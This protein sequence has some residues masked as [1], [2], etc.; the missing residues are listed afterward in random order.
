MGVIHHHAMIVVSWKKENIMAAHK[1]AKRLSP[2]TTD[3]V[4]GAANDYMSF[5]VLP[6]GSKEGW[7]ESDVGD[8]ARASLKDWID[9]Q[10]YD[11]GSNSIEYAIVSFGEL[12]PT[13]ETNQDK[14][15]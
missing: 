14:N 3:I 9:R 12:N 6:D 8:A 15:R 1:M 13:F 7:G 10:A 5:A 4:T 11:D 2:Y